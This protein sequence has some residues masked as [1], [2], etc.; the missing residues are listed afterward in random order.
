[1]GVNFPA[2]LFDSA[3][4]SS[5]VVSSFAPVPL[6]CNVAVKV[7]KAAPAIWRR[8]L[9]VDTVATVS[10]ISVARPRFARMRVNANPR[11]LDAVGRRVKSSV[12]GWTFK[13][14]IQKLSLNI[15]WI[16]LGSLALWLFPNADDPI[17]AT[18]K[19]KT[20]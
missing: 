15:S 18:G 13:K 2:A 14:S 16:C 19:A 11:I 17:F 20:G 3:A 7:G 10:A 1:M 5:L 9:R 6:P 12:S 8:L 4:V